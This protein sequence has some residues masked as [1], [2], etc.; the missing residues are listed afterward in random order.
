MRESMHNV[1]REERRSLSD[2]ELL[3]VV[4]AGWTD[5]FCAKQPA[6]RADKKRNKRRRGKR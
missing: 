2:A 5:A 6:P 1:V 3:A 4:D